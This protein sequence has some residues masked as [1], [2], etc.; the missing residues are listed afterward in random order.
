MIPIIMSIIPDAKAGNQAGVLEAIRSGTAVDE[1]DKAGRTAL[2]YA[3]AASD[4]DLMD[5]L[6][7]AGADPN[8][9]DSEGWAALHF[10][11]QNQW[12]TGIRSLVE[13]GAKIDLPD[14]H[15]NPPLFRAVFAY[16]GA[17]NAV[18]LLLALGASP[19]LKN[20]HGVS[21]RDLAETI[22][23]YDSRKFFADRGN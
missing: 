20:R 10:A 3:T 23:N 11:A 4:Q 21:P 22:A 2:L 7:Q 1:V 8:I 18:A 13:Y 5:I 14:K 9:G 16:R 19:S 15:G 6:L 12:E 17:G